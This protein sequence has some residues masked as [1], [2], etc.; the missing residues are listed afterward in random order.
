MVIVIVALVMG[1]V[2]TA[3]NLI[4]NAHLQ[5]LITEI[6]TYSSAVATF[7]QRYSCLPGDCAQA[8]TYITGATNGN[9]DGAISFA[10]GFQ[11]WTQLS[12]AG[13]VVGSFTGTAG[14]LGANDAV[15]G[16]NVPRSA[17][18]DKMGYTLFYEG[19]D[20][21]NNPNQFF[22]YTTNRNLMLF[23][24][25]NNDYTD[26]TYTYGKAL[27]PYENKEIDAKI[28][29]RMP[30]TGLVRTFK[31]GVGSCTTTNVPSTADYYVT[32]TAMACVVVYYLGQ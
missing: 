27:Y 17:I 6:Q 3:R 22:S 11:A 1:G 29:D 15:P 23:G 5:T 25:D 18:G 8:S 19:A 2:L 24:A 30:G 21:V 13:L 12:A 31:D 9:G 32:G 14:S 4:R 16:T 7:N 26:L 28:D 20:A 10:E